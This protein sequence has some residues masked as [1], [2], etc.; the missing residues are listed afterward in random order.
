MG[1]PHIYYIRAL[2]MLAHALAYDINPKLARELSEEQD[3]KV[4]E[5]YVLVRKSEL[6][7]RQFYYTAGRATQYVFEEAEEDCCDALNASIGGIAEFEDFIGL[8]EEDA[9]E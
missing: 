1:C 7:D 8:E 6:T 2:Q 4:L 9:E 5:K 3:V